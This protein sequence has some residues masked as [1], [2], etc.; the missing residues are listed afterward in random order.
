MI[1]GSVQAIIP[2]NPR[3][4]PNAVRLY[5]VARGFQQ[6][7][8]HYL[9]YEWVPTCPTTSTG[10][11]QMGTVWS[12]SVNDSAISSALQVSNG[13]ISGAVYSRMRTNIHLKG[14]L[15]QNWFY[16]NDLGEDSNPYFFAFKN[17]LA[18]SGYI[19]LHYDFEFTNPTTQM[20]TITYH[21][22]AVGDP[23]LNPDA[24]E[25]I[26]RQALT[27]TDAG[28]DKTFDPFT[29][30]IKD[31]LPDATVVLRNGVNTLIKKVGLDYSTT[32]SSNFF[33]VS[34]P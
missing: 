4:N 19:L 14:T 23:F 21:L 22:S 18:S 15:P 7:R 25:V 13:G 2:S 8:P 29:R 10:L 6:W 31:T 27:L 16:F 28:V 17:S 32:N 26:I 9:S 3:N 30:F 33:R 34:Y 11:V 12:T 24:T 1:T 5:N 20:Q